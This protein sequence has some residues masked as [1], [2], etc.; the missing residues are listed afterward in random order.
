[1]NDH[2]THY[3]IHGRV[4]GREGRELRHARVVLWWQQIRERKQLGSTETSED[5]LYRIRYQIPEHAPL[6]VLL[7][8]EAVSKDLDGPLVSPL[9]EAQPDLEIDLQVEPR[10]QSEWATLVR[11][12][13][14]LLGGLKLS[15]LVENRTNQD[16]TFLG[17]EL[18]RDTETVM[19]LSLSARMEDAFKITA[20]AFYAFLRYW[21]R[22]RISL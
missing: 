7:V 11:A 4:T 17:R 15:D 16:I 8:V 9:T 19:K 18:K 6:P 12:M 14:P 2:A 3:E 22:A 5:G 10:D 13:A 20:P 21:T 1:M